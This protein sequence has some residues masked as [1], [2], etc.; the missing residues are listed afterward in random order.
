MLPR[1]NAKRLLATLE[2]SQLETRE[3]VHDRLRQYLN[4][5]HSSKSKAS[6]SSATRGNR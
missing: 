1:R 6:A 2:R 4:A 5:Q 3:R